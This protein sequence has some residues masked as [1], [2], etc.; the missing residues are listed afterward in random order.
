MKIKL[1]ISID[2][3][4]VVSCGVML[5]CKSNEPD[6]SPEKTEEQHIAIEMYTHSTTI[7]QIE[8]LQVGLH[9]EYLH[10]EVIARLNSD[11]FLRQRLSAPFLEKSDTIFSYDEIPLV[12]ESKSYTC[13]SRD[14]AWQSSTEHL[15]PFETNAAYQLNANAPPE[16][17]RIFKTVVKDGHIKIYNHLDELIVEDLFPVVNMKTFLD[18]MKVYVQL[19]IKKVLNRAVDN[20]QIISK[21]KRQLPQSSKISQLANGHVMLESTLEELPGKTNGSPR[22]SGIIRSRTEL[23]EDMTKTMK[24]ELFQ[25]EYL[26][27]RKIYSYN[28]KTT[29]CN[30]CYDD[31]VSENPAT[32]ESES[33]MLNSK[34]YPVLHHTKEYFQRNQTYYYFKD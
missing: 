17:S 25:G 11:A 9:D 34:G 26:I 23:S 1:N 21:L 18:T 2:L 5:S 24:F 22:M 7:N 16:E 6:I 30:F 15:T 3:I 33:L 14:G 12:K 13:I 29:L 32:I 28:G 10:P 20:T 8:Y 19:N 31:I 4:I 27:Q